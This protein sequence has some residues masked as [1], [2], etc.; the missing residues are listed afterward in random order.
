MPRHGH[1]ATNGTGH[2]LGGPNKQI[3]D[4]SPLAFV[5]KEIEHQPKKNLTCVT[6]PGSITQFQHSADKLVRVR[7]LYV[8]LDLTDIHRGA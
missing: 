1:R 7:A 3:C 6:L 8:K 5:D 4:L 2:L